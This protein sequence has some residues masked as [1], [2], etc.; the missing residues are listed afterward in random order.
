MCLK[1]RENRIE[2]QRDSQ[3]VRAVV[4]LAED[5]GSEAST[6]TGGSQ[7]SISPVLGD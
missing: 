1:H 3:Q 7:T 5:L 4:A 6:H 2:D